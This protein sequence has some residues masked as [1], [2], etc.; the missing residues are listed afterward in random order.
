MP[1]ARRRRACD[2]GDRTEI[3]VDGPQVMV[4]QVSK[5]RPR[6]C[7]EK[8]SIEWSGNATKFKNRPGRPCCKGGMEVTQVPARPHD[9][10]KLPKRGASCGRAVFI[11]CQVAGD[12]DRR[13]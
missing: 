2:A 9:L 4:R 3:F 6:H 10:N 12:D 11:G 8:V 5:T 7:L 1:R 13:T